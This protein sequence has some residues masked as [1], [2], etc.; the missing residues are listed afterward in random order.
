MMAWFK[1]D[2]GAL[3]AEVVKVCLG[4]PP[5]HTRTM[6]EAFECY[7]GAKINFNVLKFATGEGFPDDGRDALRRG[8]MRSNRRYAWSVQGVRRT[9][10]RWMKG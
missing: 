8:V 1:G 10:N 4:L 2:I 9:W 3:V 7:A 5:N 6:L